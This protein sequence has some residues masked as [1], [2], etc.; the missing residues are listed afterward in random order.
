MS[1]LGPDQGVPCPYC[2]EPCD[3]DVADVGVGFIQ[4]GPY[5]CLGCGASEIGPYDEERPLSEQETKTG[6]YEPRSLPGSSA[7]VIAGKI[8]THKEARALY[9]SLYPFSATDEG[10]NFIRNKHV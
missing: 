6:W 10:Q 3:C 7:N 5:H 1:Y 8:V 9:R 4:C 2:A